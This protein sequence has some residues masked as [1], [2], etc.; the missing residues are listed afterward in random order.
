MCCPTA[1]TLGFSFYIF[2]TFFFFRRVQEKEGHKEIIGCFKWCGKRFH[3]SQERQ[4]KFQ[5]GFSGHYYV[6][7]YVAVLSQNNT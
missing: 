6:G 1:A 7:Y 5:E 2:L 3:S 4:R